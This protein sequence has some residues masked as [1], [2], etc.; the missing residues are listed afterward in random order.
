W[1]RCP[2]TAGHAVRRLTWGQGTQRRRFGN[3][4]RAARARHPL[5]A[6]REP[7][8]RRPQAR[9]IWTMRLLSPYRPRSMRSN[10]RGVSAMR[11]LF[12]AALIAALAGLSAPA[13]AQGAQVG[14]G[15]SGWTGFAPLTLAKEAGIF[16]KNGLDV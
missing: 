6:C 16:K 14:V 13:L 15:I 8:C 10:R 9:L 2:R 4:R 11:C 7:R 5:T 12:R 3:R 1:A